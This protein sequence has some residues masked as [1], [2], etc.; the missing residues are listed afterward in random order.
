[1]SSPSDDSEGVTPLWP[2]APPPEPAGSWFLESFEE[3]GKTMRRVAVE[4][5]PFRIG[6]RTG[7]ELSLP[8]DLVSKEHAELS[9]EGARLRVRDLGSTNGTFVNR[10]RVSEAT[11]RAGDILHFAHFE[12]R[13]GCSSPER[14][15]PPDSSTVGASEIVLP[16]RFKEG[17][18]ELGELLRIGA[19]EAFFQPILGLADMQVAAYESLGRGRHREL[20]ESPLELFAIASTM[21]AEIALSQLFR[22]KAAA[23]AQS[24]VAFPPLFLNIHPIE[25]HAPSLVESLAE[26]KQQAPHL[27]L[28]LEVHETAVTDP[29]SI[30]GLRATLSAMSIGMA[31]DD[32]GAGQARLLELGEVPPDYLKF[33]MKLIR[34]IDQAPASR[35]RLLGSLV[36]AAKDLGV[37]TVAEG[38]ETHGES[39][40]CIEVGFD[41][42]QGYLYGWPVPIHK[43]AAS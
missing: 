19:A 7:L 22:K 24:R 9:V 26:L 27:V 8:S 35:V 43:I 2:G 31:Y 17:S 21:G 18:R 30:G 20:P 12:F 34:G 13:V 3:V 10:E 23:A 41:L 16:N 14:E 29:A 11:L 25:L 32:F 33:D 42:A 1:V 4:A 15:A 28:N 38:V 37:K 6:R 5:R 36:R 39:K 40:T